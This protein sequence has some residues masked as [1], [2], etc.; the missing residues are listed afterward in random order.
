MGS[1]LNLKKQRGGA[2]E[3]KKKKA[4]KKGADPLAESACYSPLPDFQRS[5]V[6]HSEITIALVKQEATGGEKS[7]LSF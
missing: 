6:V 3:E 2:T 7:N 4:P 5:T 1:S